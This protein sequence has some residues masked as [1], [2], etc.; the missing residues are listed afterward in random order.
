L[1][2]TGWWECERNLSQEQLAE[3]TGFHRTYIGMVER[4]S[5]INSTICGI[6]TLT[7]KSPSRSHQIVTISRPDRFIPHGRMNLE[8]ADANGASKFGLENVFQLLDSLTCKPNT[9]ALLT[10]YLPLR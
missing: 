3:L 8:P 10:R 7:E 5:L 9:L 2:R 4:G 6:P 1:S